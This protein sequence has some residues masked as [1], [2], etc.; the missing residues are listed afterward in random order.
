MIKGGILSGK[1]SD[2]EL[3]LKQRQ[4]ISEKQR[5]KVPKKTPKVPKEIPKVSS[6]IPPKPTN[7]GWSVF[8]ILTVLFLNFQI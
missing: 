3:F 5:R 6:K 7:K 4:E 2:Y 8:G 1:Q